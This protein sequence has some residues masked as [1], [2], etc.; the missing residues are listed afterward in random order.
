[1]VGTVTA[2]TVEKCFIHNVLIPF[3]Y[4]GVDGFII[5]D[6]YIEETWGKEAI[7]GQSTM[8]NGTISRNVFKNT[9][10]DVGGTGNTGTAPIGIWDGGAGN[11]DNVDIYGNLFWN[12]KEIPYTNAGI[13]V[14]GDNGVNAAG[15]GANNINIF[16]NTFAG[17]T[18][19]LIIV[20][21]DT[22]N[23]NIQNNLWYDNV[24]GNSATVQGGSGNTVNNNI[25]A[26]SNPFASYTHYGA[27]ADLH[28]N[29]AIAGITLGSTYNLDLEGQTRGA[30][31]VWDVG[32]YEF[33]AGGG[34]P[35]ATSKHKLNGFRSSGFIVK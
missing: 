33:T 19:A 22:G 13:L 20:R 1:M 35:V 2:V 25:A 5:R 34:G 10:Q 12:T 17:L 8:K 30:D 31:G 14:G 24:Q 26:G 23:C 16:N 7:R 6:N 18:H 32:A 11:F 27:S 15:A 21:S 28:L 29:A 9:T 3:Q 4:T